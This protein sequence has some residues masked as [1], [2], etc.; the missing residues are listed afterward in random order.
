MNETLRLY[1]IVPFNVR[2]ALRD[3]TLPRGGGKDGSQPVGVLKDTP[4]GYSTLVMQRR[5]DIYPDPS[6]GFPDKDTFVPERWDDW[7]PKH[8]TY[9]TI[10]PPR[11]ITPSVNTD[12]LQTDTFH[13]TVARASA[14]V[15]NSRSRRWRTRSH[16]SCRDTRNWR[17]GC[18]RRQ[19]GR[20]I[21]CY[22]LPVVYK[23]LSMRQRNRL[24]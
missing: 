17:T 11:S 21:S 5:A 20:R 24:I 22:S 12:P 1:P 4:I 10:L 13:S 16:A 7:S 2:M 8:W 3:C 23:W 14:S 15:S 19:S 9:V 6:T 18:R